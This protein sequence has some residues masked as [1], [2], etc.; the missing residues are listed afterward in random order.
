MV[1]AMGKPLKVE[2]RY[3]FNEGSCGGKSNFTPA[4]I[5]VAVVQ[6]RLQGKARRN[7]L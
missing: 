4:V 5:T 1:K 6:S 3:I 2:N 7:A